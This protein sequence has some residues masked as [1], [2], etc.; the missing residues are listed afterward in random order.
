[1]WGY[2]TRNQGRGGDSLNASANVSGRSSSA[3]VKNG[4][5]Q[6]FGRGRARRSAAQKLRLVHYRNATSALIA[7][8]IP[9]PRIVNSTAAIDPTVWLT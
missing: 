2:S 6:T 8:S 1:M 3:N 9:S 4:R 7:S 5:G